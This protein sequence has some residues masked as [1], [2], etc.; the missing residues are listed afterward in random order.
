MRLTNKSHI[1]SIWTERVVFSAHPKTEM[2]HVF[3]CFIHLNNCLQLIILHQKADSVLNN[4]FYHFVA[5]TDIV[6]YFF[7]KLLI[8]IYIITKDDPTASVKTDIHWKH[9]ICFF[10]EPEQLSA[11]MKYILRTL[12][13]KNAKSFWKCTTCTFFCISK[14]FIKITFFIKQYFHK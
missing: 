2:T 6:T 5:L 13:L 8:S 3:I 9:I 14:Y 4:V 10:C 11:F 12:Y 1:I 7:L